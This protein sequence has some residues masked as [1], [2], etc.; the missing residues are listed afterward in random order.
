VSWPSDYGDHKRGTQ[1]SGVGGTSVASPLVMGLWASMESA[2]ANGLGL[3]SYDFYNQYNKINPAKTANGP[4]GVVFVANS[5]PKP[6]P[7]LPGHHP[8]YER[9][10]CG[11]ARV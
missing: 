2:H 9:G 6:V 5:S 7:G 8:G 4:F 10:L 3:A 11:Q 1:P